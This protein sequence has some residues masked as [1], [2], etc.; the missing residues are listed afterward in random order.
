MIAPLPS[1]LSAVPPA[2]TTPCDTLV[3]LGVGNAVGAAKEGAGEGGWEEGWAIV[4]SCVG[5]RVWIAVGS[6]DGRGVG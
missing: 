5:A 4:G 6:L 3:G 2:R 1:L